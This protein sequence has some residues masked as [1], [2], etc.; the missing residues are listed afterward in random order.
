[1]GLTL[2]L[3]LSPFLLF[4]LSPPSFSR[5]LSPPLPV[6]LVRV[7]EVQESSEQ[8]MCSWLLFRAIMADAVCSWAPFKAGMAPPHTVDS[9]QDAQFRH[10]SCL[11]FKAP[12]RP[13]IMLSPVVFLHLLSPDRFPKLTILLPSVAG[14]MCAGDRLNLFLNARPFC[15]Q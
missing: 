15:C 4:F 10:S 8:P 3:F 7:A 6:I 12:P 2:L 1:M 9:F 5:S 13:P 11:R 14:L